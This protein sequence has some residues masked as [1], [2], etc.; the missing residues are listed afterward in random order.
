MIELK[1]FQKIIR[2]PYIVPIRKRQESITTEIIEIASGAEAI[3]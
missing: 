2:P 1:F 3:Q